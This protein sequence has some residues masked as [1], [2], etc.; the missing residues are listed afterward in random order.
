MIGE[1]L[2]LIGEGKMPC[3]VEW[4]QTEEQEAVVEGGEGDYQIHIRTF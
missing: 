4:D 1:G 2:L 3:D